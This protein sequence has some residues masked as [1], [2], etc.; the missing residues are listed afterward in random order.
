ML[1][2]GAAP[3]PRRTFRRVGYWCVPTDEGESIG[4]TSW[5]GGPIFGARGLPKIAQEP[6]G[7]M[8]TPRSIFRTRRAAWFAFFPES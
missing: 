4:Y 3:Q 1:A 2:P 6:G 5:V 7:H 8:A